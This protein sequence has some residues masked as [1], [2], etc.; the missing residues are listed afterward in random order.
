MLYQGGQ[1]EGEILPL[2][3]LNSINT[4]FYSLTYR[5][6]EGMCYTI[7]TVGQGEIEVERSRKSRVEK[8]EGIRR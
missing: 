3:V 4:E 2:L 6:L 1:D 7:F 8:T 5:N